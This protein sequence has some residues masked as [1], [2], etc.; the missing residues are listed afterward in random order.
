MAS[1]FGGGAGGVD[2]AERRAAAVALMPRPDGVAV[3]ATV[4][5]EHSRLLALQRAKEHVLQQQRVCC[6]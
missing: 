4:E 1:A 2:D 5:D 6:P 3:G